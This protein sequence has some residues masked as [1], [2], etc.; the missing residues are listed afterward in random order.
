MPLRSFADVPNR[1]VRLC[2]QEAGR[3]YDANRG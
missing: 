1:I 2:L 3:Q